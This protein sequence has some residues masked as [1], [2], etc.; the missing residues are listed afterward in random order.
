MSELQAATN[1]KKESIL[2][3]LLENL[4]REGYNASSGSE[5][6]TDY[7]GNET[8]ETV[9]EISGSPISRIALL[10]YDYGNSR[11]SFRYRY[12]VDL[13]GYLPA[14]AGKLLY[15]RLKPVKENKILGI[16]SGD[17]T[18]VHW[19]GQQAASQL[20]SDT[21][22]SAKVLELVR[23]AG[24]T[25]VQVYVKSADTVEILGPRLTAPFSLLAGEELMRGFTEEAVSACRLDIFEQIG[26]YIQE[27]IRTA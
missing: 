18:G 3:E 23:Q 22:L 25:D 26:R 15:S 7:F 2:R 5:P 13:G 19:E 4:S 12:R 24:D 10:A 17:L 1:R 6:A 11:T 21:A 14:A 8:G 9:I 16:F 27:V 20:N